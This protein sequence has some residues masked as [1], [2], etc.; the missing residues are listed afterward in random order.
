MCC[1]DTHRLFFLPPT[2][3]H[4]RMPRTTTPTNDFLP[5]F[6]SCFAEMQT[7]DD[8]EE[9]ISPAVHAQMQAKWKELSKKRWAGSTLKGARISA[10]RL[11]PLP[12]PQLVLVGF[13]GRVVL[14]V[15]AEVCFCV[16]AVLA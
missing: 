14:C 9:G 10:V 6:F 1:I 2:P 5:F 15:L 8:G 4:S 7:E 11:P 12:L 3:R 13:C 16:L